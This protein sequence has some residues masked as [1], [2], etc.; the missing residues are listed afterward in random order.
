MV[1]L[2][3]GGC[4]AVL[5]SSIMLFS[6]KFDTAMQDKVGVA[7]NTVEYDINEFI[8]K[9]QI[10][11]SALG[12]NRDLSEAI[13]NNDREGIFNAANT[14]KMMAQL[15]FCTIVDA[16]GSVLIRVHDPG[17]DAGGSLAELPHVISALEGR[18]ETYIVPG[19]SIKLGVMAG[20]PVYD[21]HGNIVGAISLGFRLDIQEFAQR[22]K[23]HSG[24]D[25]TVFM[26]DERVSTTVVGQDGETMLGT[27]ASDYIIE[28]LFAGESY[29]GSTQIFDRNVL[30][31]YAPLFGADDSVVGIIAVGYFTEDDTREITF[32]VL[33]GILI[34]LVILAVCL[35]IAKF[36]SVAIENRLD[37]M[38]EDLRLAVES[39]ETAN[40]AKSS[41]L[42]TM[43]HEI[44][45][46]MNAIIGMTTIGKLTDDA[47][48]RADAFEKISG[49]SK[50]LL[51]IIND[52]LDFSK[53][54][55]GKFELS[56]ASFEFVKM[57]QRVVDIINLRV[58]ERRQTF[59]VD[60][61]KNIPKT[62][63]GD[64]Q[65]LSQV[66]TN[67]LSNAVKFT[68]EEGS[69]SLASNLVSEEGDICMIQIS[70][71]DTGIG[72]PDDQKDRVFLSFEQAEAGTSRKYG[73]TGLGLPI[74]KRIVELMDG[75]IWVE[76]ELG[77]GSKF[78]FTVMLRHG[79]EEKKRRLD[80]SVNWDNVRLFV[81]DD[82]PE[83]LEFFSTITESMGVTCTVAANSEE[84][85]ALFEKDSNHNIYF[86]DWKLPGMN[87]GELV[88]QIKEKAT[89]DPI[90]I[91]FSSSDWSTI[92]EEA[93]STGADKFL[94]K[95]LLPSVIHDVVNEFI[96]V[97]DASLSDDYIGH[98]DDLTGHTVL[99]AED[100]EINREIVLSLLEPTHVSIECAENGAQAV[101]MFTSAPDKYD[102]IFMDIQMPE[103]DGYEATR[104]IRGSGV[105]G[106]DKVPIIAMTANVFR[107]D[108]EKCHRTGMNGHVGKPIDIDEIC[109]VLHH[110]LLH[111]KNEL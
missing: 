43:S 1:A 74:S 106:A 58:D 109:R 85:A 30:V 40:Q 101:D 4:V 46:P 71:E 107:E 64:D 55:S 39:A 36:V 8:V 51:G 41:F 13:I 59:H 49:A 110:Y 42:A 33:T 10:T 3:I 111:P 15:D 105:P 96:G 97:G 98:I 9:A 90:I 72:I 65:R 27:S 75:N 38:Q 20:A 104:R 61:D 95:P 52:V 91:I 83:I 48:K 29:V 7:M 22:L 100:V 26:Y 31:S 45:T 37:C 78:I 53:I 17:N 24:C 18:V 47:N 77:K 14:L 60:I 99:L 11:A 56:P 84:A 63:I 50:H 21:N 70:V 93:R 6:N 79:A 5:F 103:M 28:K 102:M 81:V 34:T 35:F 89:N 68:P 73:G 32:F 54:E 86:I 12:E 25:I 62:L 80:E 2:T 82:E 76:S 92:E 66:I 19:V 87:G 57:V 88:R 16:E 67:L 44:R 94:S 69:I 108:I 23:A